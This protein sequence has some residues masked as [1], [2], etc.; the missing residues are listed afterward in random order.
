MELSDLRIFLAVSRTSG[1]TRAAQ[2]LHTVQSNISA[3]INALEKELGVSL[4]RRH[5]RGVALT[6]AGERLL[7]YAERIDRLMDEARCA[8]DDEADPSGSLR[9]G[10]METT[11]GLRLPAVLSAFADNHP[12]VDLSLTTGPTDD[13]VQ[14]VLDYHLEGALVAGPVQLDELVETE[15]FVEELVIVTAGRVTVLDTVLRSP[16]ILVFRAG[17]SYRRRLENILLARGAVGVRCLEFGTLEGILGCVAAGMGI[18][19]L[20]AGVV[21]QS[22]SRELVRVHRLPE[23][24]R[25]AGTVFVRRA[26]VLPSPAV[27]R[28]LEHLRAASQA[29]NLR[30]VGGGTSAAQ[31]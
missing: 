29:P 9:V 25:W 17:C 11:A 2:E 14:A 22:V 30:I 18:T 8:V 6:N 10:A 3:R 1:I 15:V 4:F 19:L 27:S 16:K 13:L 7:P 23:A 28:F 12:R 26:D 5:A 20:P 21:E 24:E 31:Q